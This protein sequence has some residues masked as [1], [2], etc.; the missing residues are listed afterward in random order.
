MV[1]SRTRCYRQRLNFEPETCVARKKATLRHHAQRH[2]D[3]ASAHFI[4]LQLLG[5]AASCA[6]FPFSARRNSNWSPTHV[7]VRNTVCAGSSNTL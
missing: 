4:H 3:E 6:E 1:E 2:A 5:E 7:P